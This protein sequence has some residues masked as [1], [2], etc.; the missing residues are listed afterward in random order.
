MGLF[1]TFT[2]YDERVV[3]SEGHDLSYVEFQTKDLG[4]TMG[5]WTIEGGRL[6]GQPGGWGVEPDMPVTETLYVYSSCPLCPA[7]VQAATANIVDTP[8]DFLIAIRDNLVVTVERI[9]ESAA[10]FV[11]TAPHD[12]GMQGCVG[13][14]SREDAWQVQ[15]D[16]RTATSARPDAVEVGEALARLR[17]RGVPVE[18]W[19]REAADN[20]ARLLEK[21]PISRD[22]KDVRTIVNKAL[23]SFPANQQ[24]ALN[25]LFGLKAEQ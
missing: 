15:R 21:H 23:E 18:K 16:Y 17:E 2:I 1:D 9:S 14:M 22:S 19:V 20:R 13:P 11:A 12:P 24:E 8:L 4:Q 3:C 7:F 6:Y 5:H 10:E 25:A